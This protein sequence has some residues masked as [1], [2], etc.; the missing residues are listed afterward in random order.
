[1]RVPQSA[2]WGYVSPSLSRSKRP[3][4]ASSGFQRSPIRATRSGTLKTVKSRELAA[5]LDLL[6]RHR[7]RDGRRFIGA[8]GIYRGQRFTAGVLIVIDE[9]AAG[10]SRR[11]TSAVSTSG[12]AWQSDGRSPWRLPRLRAGSDRCGSHV[13]VDAPLPVVFTKGVMP[14]PLQHVAHDQSGFPHDRKGRVRESDRGRSAC[15]GDDRIVAERV[16][17][18]EIDAAEI[19]QP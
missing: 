14:I 9:H 15:R 6:P 12:C 4:F 17:R 19:D 10:G 5:G 3:R 7:R 13:D 18:I 8:H 11:G 16:P 1:M 2:A